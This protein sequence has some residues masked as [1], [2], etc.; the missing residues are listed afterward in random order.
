V[1]ARADRYGRNVAGEARYDAVADFYAAGWA[2]GDDPVS[3]SL[4][5]LTGD[6]AGRR[7][8]EIACGHGR[9]TRELARQG[10]AVTGVDISGAMIANAE[11]AEREKPLGIQ[12]VR[13]D[14]ADPALLPGEVFD[15]VV[16]SFG[17]SDIDDL[18]GTLANTHRLLRQDGVFAF[19][20][21]HPCFAGGAD[22]SGSWPSGGTYYDE[23][24]WQADGSLST[25][26]QQVGANHRSLSTYLNSLRRHGLLLDE[27]AEPAPA[28]E[29]AATRPDAARFPVFLVARCLNRDKEHVAHSA[30][31]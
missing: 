1:T 15:V 17:L 13:A 22:V 11:S 9:I 12:Y 16:C 23:R 10:A 19:S 14:V 31:G 26:R 21:L 25:L 30:A 5:V 28:A 20:I 7:V 27:I 18:D 29:W 8:L 2:G 6:V 24:W 4:A 3:V